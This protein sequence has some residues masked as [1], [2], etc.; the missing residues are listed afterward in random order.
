MDA[1]L[2]K[3]QADYEIARAEEQGRDTTALEAYKKQLDIDYAEKI[4]QTEIQ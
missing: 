1:L 3:Q 4:R 2:A